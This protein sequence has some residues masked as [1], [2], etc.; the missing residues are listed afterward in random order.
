MATERVKLVRGPPLRQ[1]DEAEATRIE[2]D[3]KKMSSVD[4]E[5]LVHE[6]QIHQIEL[7]MQNDEL[8]R[9][10]QELTESRAMYSDLYDFAP[11]GYFTCDS[12]GKI[13]EVNLTTASMLGIERINLLHK[14]F[15]RF[16][17]GEDGNTIHN[18]LLGIFQSGN[19]QTCEVRLKWNETQLYVRLESTLRET[20]DGPKCRTA[21][22]NISSR[23]RSENALQL[24]ETRFRELF[25]NMSS[26]V[27]IYEAVGAAEDFVFKDVNRA[28]EQIDGVHR[29]QIVGERITDVFPG[30][31]E[32]G[33]FD[34]FQ[35][36][37]NTGKAESHPVSIYKDNRLEVFR[38]N[39]IFKLPSR[40]IIGIYED[41]T[42]RKQTEEQASKARELL[43]VDKLRSALLASVSHELRTPLAAIKGIADT[44]IQPDVQW[45]TETQKDF[46]RT[47]NRE[48][49]VL[50]RIID[51][52][53]D[54]S[55]LESGIVTIER[56]TSILS[57]VMINIK[58]ELRYLA[59]NHNLQVN[60]PVNLPIINIDEVRIG[61]V[62]TNLV[63]NAAHNSENGTM[64]TVEATTTNDQLIV[65]VSDC[66]PSA[67]MGHF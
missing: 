24:S 57:A 8:R 65:T 61:Q 30:V 46:L 25:E 56:Q 53:V 4:I 2:T 9:T 51:D 19:P 32:F 52:L 28:G 13:L 67:K 62:I 16:V 50:V 63:K 7:Q 48:S 26:G 20:S 36:V 6:L 54:M 39:Y 21:I 10:E 38:E 15:Q 49:D 14:H 5:K 40:E 22:I 42:E 47:I 55:L 12:Q 41:V 31:K 29:E 3:I 59:M 43:E 17:V 1:H 18:H 34:A 11:V 35:R 33:L 44:L 23:K 66:P 37:W 58:E 27:A 45:D 60:V 64:I